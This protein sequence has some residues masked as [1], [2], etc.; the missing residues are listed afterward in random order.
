MIYYNTD[1]NAYCSA[2]NPQ[3]FE[4]REHNTVQICTFLYTRKLYSYSHFEIF[5]TFVVLRVRLTKNQQ[6]HSDIQPAAQQMF[7]CLFTY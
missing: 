3:Y 1:N 6:I 2:V 5:V 7:I 4:T